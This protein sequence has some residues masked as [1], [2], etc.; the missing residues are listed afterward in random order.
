MRADA[1]RL[2]AGRAQHRRVINHHLLPEPRASK[3]GA[4][5]VGGSEVSAA[6]AEQGKVG[7]GEGGA[8]GGDFGE[9]GRVQRSAWEPWY[10]NGK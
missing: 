4:G 9:L 2:G 1:L 8:R 6:D 5:E 10:S 3:V 7:K